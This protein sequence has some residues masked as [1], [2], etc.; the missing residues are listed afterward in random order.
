M[1]ASCETSNQNAGILKAT[2]E[3]K[4]EGIVRNGMNSRSDG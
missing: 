2:V 3:K 1:S 4:L